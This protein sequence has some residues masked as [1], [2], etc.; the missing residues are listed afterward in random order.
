MTAP[1]KEVAKLHCILLYYYVPESPTIVE[2]LTSTGQSRL[3]AKNNEY[4]KCT[5]NKIWQS[6]VYQFDHK[7]RS[8]GWHSNKC[9]SDCWY[10]K[11]RK[12]YWINVRE[13]KYKN[14]Q[15]IN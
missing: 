8:D 4:L 5:G 9:K 1:K 15:K 6:L 10:K 11:E 7:G 14:I 3:C 2:K 13:Q 12:E